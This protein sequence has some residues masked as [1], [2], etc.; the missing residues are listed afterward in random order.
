[1]AANA[2]WHNRPLNVPIDVVGFYGVASDAEQWFCDCAYELSNSGKGRH[3]KAR[4][5]KIYEC[6]RITNNKYADIEHDK[7][8]RRAIARQRRLPMV[9]VTTII[10]RRRLSF[11]IP[12]TRKAIS[13]F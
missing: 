4:Y 12:A 10:T 13:N 3:Q 7:F 1:M 2:P 11:A 5:A 8:F 9:S 6:S